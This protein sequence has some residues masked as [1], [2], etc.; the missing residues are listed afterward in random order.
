[1]IHI[2]C[3]D[4]KGKTSAAAGLAIRCAGAGMKAAFFQF[5]KNGTSSEIISLKK[6][7]IKVSC[8]EECCKF[9]FEM[10]PDEK[11]SVKNAQDQ[12]LSEAESLTEKGFDLI[13]LD[14]F[15][16]ALTTKTLSHEKAMQFVE[17]FPAASELVLTGRDPEEFF[18]ERAD[19]I[20][21]I[22]AVRH[23]YS[24]GV[25]ARRGIEY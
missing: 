11:A 4:G 7:G 22:Q 16:G 10:T 14:E 17:G 3:G 13:V 24:K 9:T 15:F 23:P 8:C 12:M 19:Y 20:S 25:P 6:L 18:L 2:Y 21:Q 1:M 5:L